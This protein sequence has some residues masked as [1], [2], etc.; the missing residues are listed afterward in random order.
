MARYVSRSKMEPI[1]AFEL[2]SFPEPNS[3]CFIWM[4]PQLTARKGYGN[5]LCNGVQTRAHRAAWQFYKGEIPDGLHVLH[6]CDTPICVNPGHLFLGTQQD[7]MKDKRRKGRAPKGEKHWKYAG[8]RYVGK[9]ARRT[10]VRQRY[11]E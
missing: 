11:G 7:N 8:G 5:F 10:N 9:F 1:E 2:R 4:G 6:R 3:G